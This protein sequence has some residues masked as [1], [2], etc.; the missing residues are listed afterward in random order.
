MSDQVLF[1]IDD[2]F[3]Q[4]P[5]ARLPDRSASGTSTPSSSTFQRYHIETRSTPD[6]VPFPSRFRV[7]V[8]KH[9]LIGMLIRELFEYKGNFQVA[10]SRP[11]L[12]GVFSGPVGGLAP[13]GEFCVGCLRCTVQYPHIVQI[14][15]NPER[16]R[17]G[18][19]FVKPEYVDTIM[20]EA[21]DGRV[22]VRGA[23]YRGLFGGEGWDGLWTDMSEIVRP[24]RDGI[25][26]REFISTAVDIGEKPP[27]LRFDKQGEVVVPVP[28][29]ITTQVPFLFDV[30][31]Y[32][33]QSK[34]LLPIFSE[35][36]RQIESLAVIPIQS[37]VELSLIGQ[38]LVP[39]ITPDSLSWLDQLSSSPH[40]LM[41]DG[42]D[43][44]CY[45]ELK[46]RFSGTVVCVRVPMDTNLVEMAQQG[47]RVFH[48]T[49]NYH[50]YIGNRFVIDLIQQAHRSLVDAGIR[51]EVTLIGSGGIVLAEHV[52]KAI[53]CGLDAVALDVALAV[54]LQAHFKG[55]C[56]DQETVS[57]SFPRLNKDWGVQRL[58]NLAASWRDQLLEVMGAMGMR[59]VRRLR[60]EIGRCMF[61]KDLEREIFAEPGETEAEYEAKR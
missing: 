39:L 10:L 34:L 6:I 41:L 18:D 38:H 47:V 27:F 43:L 24:T 20:Y 22:P 3:E 2:A 56:I 21:R 54:A 50:G 53:I 14:Y 51:E 11:C 52:P 9:G 61:Q 58:M 16:R 59:E 8:K 15:P 31:A 12:Y 13:R 26:G 19:S 30:P 35:A 29:M 4:L 60:G 42:W 55:E 49:A 33:A 44:E 45:E 28:A 25:H 57:L 1:S 48:L 7:K 36:A 5:P 46:R 32:T 23:G 17:L 37:V 40:M